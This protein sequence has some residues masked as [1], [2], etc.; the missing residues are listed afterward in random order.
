MALLTT[1]EVGKRL[2]ISARQVRYLIKAGKIKAT[3]YGRRM[4]LIEES[5]IEGMAK[6]GE[7]GRLPGRPKGSGAKKSA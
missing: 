3:V 7:P 1:E 5:A 2:K 6:K 4:E